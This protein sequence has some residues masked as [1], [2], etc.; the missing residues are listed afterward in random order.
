VD[1][2]QL[3][4]ADV[5]DNRAQE[6]SAISRGLKEIAM[7]YH[8]P[9]IAI[10]QFNRGA[11]NA[12]LFDIMSYLKES[13]GIEQD[14]STILYVQVEKTEDRKQIRDAK[15]TILKNR[16]GATFASIPLNYRGEIFTFYETYAE[17]ENDTYHL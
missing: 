2:L 12:S 13:S 16:N 7:T 5:S 15:L 14:A 9:V 3:M 6:V 4:K 8:I 10:C 11:V 17:H 1:Y